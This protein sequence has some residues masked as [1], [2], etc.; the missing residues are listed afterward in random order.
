MFTYTI[1]S[2]TAYHKRKRFYSNDRNQYE[3]NE[4]WFHRVF[5]SLNGCEFGELTDFMLIDKFI[6]GLN[7]ETFQKY[8]VNTALSV[9]DALSIG[10]NKD[11]NQKS[12]F[13]ETS[14]LAITPDIR[15]FIAED[16]IKLEVSTK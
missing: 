16:D 8:A 4:E 2:S 14:E 15:E 3:T 5:E 11:D 12:N 6:A 1:P 10:L 7:D 9:N 13:H